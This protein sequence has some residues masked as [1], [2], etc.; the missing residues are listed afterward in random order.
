MGRPWDDLI[1]VGK[2]C[3]HV[4]VC[5]YS[6]DLLLLLSSLCRHNIKTYFFFH[7][8]SRF[9]FFLFKF[10]ENLNFVNRRWFRVNE[11]VERNRG[12]C[13][14]AFCCMW[15]VC[16]VFLHNIGM[17][18][19]DGTKWDHNSFWSGLFMSLGLPRI[20]LWPLLCRNRT[21][22]NHGSIS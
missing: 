20:S 21:H 6:H 8:S 22:R 18:F 19:R 9:L 14:I 3:V 7:L 15:Q 11:S 13:V 16:G 2:H 17:F 4:C 1:T 5:M 12:S 10:K